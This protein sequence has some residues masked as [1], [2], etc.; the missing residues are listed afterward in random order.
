[1]ALKKRNLIEVVN[2]LGG[3]GIETFRNNAVIVNAGKRSP[4]CYYIKE[5]L[6][7]VYD[8]DP[9]GNIKTMLLLVRGQMFPLIWGFDHP[10]ATA[11]YYTAV[12]KTT[13]VK[14]DT[15][16]LKEALANDANIAHES[17]MQFVYLMWDAMERIKCLQMPY[18]YEKLLRLLPYVAAKLGTNVGRNRCKLIYK[19]TQDEI[20]QLAGATRESVS[21]H[22]GKLSKDGV[23]ERSAHSFIINMDKIPDEYIHSYWFNESP[24]M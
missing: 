16:K 12:G 24:K 7:K 2:E 21:T 22:L 4:Y 20:A 17:L 18:T 11:Y 9:Q 1:M 6:V 14:V 10:P 13:L 3:E 23:I 5:G 8:L 19:I 15:N